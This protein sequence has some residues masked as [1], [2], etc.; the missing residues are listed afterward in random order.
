MLDILEGFELGISLA[1]ASL[2]TYLFIRNYFDYIVAIPFILFICIRFLIGRYVKKKG[3]EI[4]DMELWQQFDNDVVIPE[5]IAIG[6][7]TAICSFFCAIGGGLL[8]FFSLFH[9]YE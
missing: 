6:T 3:W 8:F 1:L 9:I 4:P 5:W 7:I 2:P